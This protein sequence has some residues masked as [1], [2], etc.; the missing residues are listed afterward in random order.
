MSST[1]RI[2]AAVLALVACK[3]EAD[4]LT[5]DAVD[6]LK[7]CEIRAAHDKFAAAHA[8]DPDHPQAALGFALT[9][10]ALLP[11][12][13]I[14]TRVLA[15]FGFTAAIDMQTLVFGTDGAL[16]RHARGDTCDSIDAFVDTT[17][18][19]PPLANPSIDEATLIDPALTG[20]DLVA[21]ASELAPRLE[22]IASALEVAARGMP[23]PVEVEGGCG[24]GKVTFQAPEL[25]AAAA[26]LEA[27]RSAIQLGEAY[28]WGVAVRAFAEAQDGG[29]PD[30]ANLLNAHIGRVTDPAGSPEARTTLARALDL[31][32]SAIDAAKVATADPDSLFAWTVIPDDLL[33]GIRAMAVS[34]RATVDGSAMLADITPALS[35]DLTSV[36]TN[37]I[38]FQTLS[39][40]L[41]SLDV[42]SQLVISDVLFQEGLARLFSVNPFAD[43]ATFE[44]AHTTRWD[45]L[46]EASITQPLD[47]YDAVYNCMVEGI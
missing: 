22:K 41:F 28:D 24:F 26:V 5:L 47:R 3:S 18:P 7:D 10:L 6:D 34:A 1:L 30:Y 12:D 2:V 15:R 40:P 25:Y 37:P 29:D 44:W 32:V 38:D 43:E 36:F 42:D 17:V 33:D 4:D 11:E 21:E 27:I 23:G 13:P 46:D 39:Q 14:V 8:S 19:Y 16:A 9:D 31:A 45:E 35:L 20:D